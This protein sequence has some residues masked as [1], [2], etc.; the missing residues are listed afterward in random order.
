MLPEFLKNRKYSGRSCIFFAKCHPV[1]AGKDSLPGKGMKKEGRCITRGDTTYNKL[2]REPDA[3]IVPR[4]TCLLGKN[5]TATGVFFK[6]RKQKNRI[7]FAENPFPF[8]GVKK[9]SEFL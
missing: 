2:K 1:R 8:S 4:R 5:I 3:N 6:S 9:F 7:C